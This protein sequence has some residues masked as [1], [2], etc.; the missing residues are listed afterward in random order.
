MGQKDS[1]FLEYCRGFMYGFAIKSRTVVISLKT[2]ISFDH[3][4][5]MAHCT[6]PRIFHIQTN[7]LLKY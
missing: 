7:F 3:I 5:L 6:L 1:S 4:Q 2:N